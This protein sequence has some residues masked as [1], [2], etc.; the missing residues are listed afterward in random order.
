MPK[1]KVIEI[2]Y[3][4]HQKLT[5]SLTLTLVLYI[6]QHIIKKTNT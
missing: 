2:Q 6:Q 4:L 1:D 3:V 5:S